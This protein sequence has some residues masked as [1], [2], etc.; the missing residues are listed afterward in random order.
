MLPFKYQLLIQKIERDFK[1]VPHPGRNIGDPFETRQFEGKTWQQISLRDID[2]TNWLYS[3]SPEA[4]HYFLPAY[5]I[6]M[7]R[8]PMRVNGMALSN[9]IRD[10]WNYDSF[11]RLKKKDFLNK[12]FSKPQRKTLVE[13]LQAFE[14]IFLESGGIGEKNVNDWE[15]PEIRESLSKAIAYWSDGL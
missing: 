7:L 12:R 10:L 1:S 11:H 13:F 9:V 5:L 3:F 6:A 8:N 4:L 15:K 14:E 2:A